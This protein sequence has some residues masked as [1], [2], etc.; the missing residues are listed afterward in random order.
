MLTK[1]S[2]AV[3]ATALMLSFSAKVWAADVSAP[4]AA[5]AHVLSSPVPLAP[6]KAAGISRAQDFSERPLFIAGGLAVLGVGIGLIASNH[7]D[8]SSLSSTSSTTSS[9]AH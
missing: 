2:F 1:T 7:G 5:H 6:G 8:H 4:I 3:I 9:G